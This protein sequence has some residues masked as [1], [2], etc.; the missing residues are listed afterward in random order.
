MD[1][2]RH[3]RL[4]LEDLPKALLQ[5]RERSISDSDGSTKTRQVRPKPASEQRKPIALLDDELVPAS[6]GVHERLLRGVEPFPTG[7]LTGYKPGFLSGW[8]V[9]RYQIDL[10]GAAQ[11]ARARMDAQIRSMCASAVPGDTHRNLQVRSHYSQQTFKHV[12]V[13][14]WLLSYNFGRRAFQVVIN[15]FTGKTAGEYPKSWIKITLACYSCCV[16]GHHRPHCESLRRQAVVY[17]QMRI[18]RFPLLDSFAALPA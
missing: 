18:C 1:V 5:L 17:K 6:R 13:P 9:E 10:V 16:V 12:L 4:A 7:E 2:R 11:A 15:G 8:V 3:G 14:I